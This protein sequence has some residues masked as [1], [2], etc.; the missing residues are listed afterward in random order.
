MV[1]AALGE[2]SEEPLPSSCVW[3]PSGCFDSFHQTVPEPPGDPGGV[4]LS[5]TALGGREGTFLL[6]RLGGWW[7]KPPPIVQQGKRSL[8]EG[9]DMPEATPLAQGFPSEP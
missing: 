4:L 8:R 7:E 3:E 2:K 1:A 6:P 5:Q 9:R